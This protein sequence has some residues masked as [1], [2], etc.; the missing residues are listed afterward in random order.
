M[1]LFT[2]IGDIAIQRKEII[3]SPTET[4]I[5]I[6]GYHD[7]RIVYEPVRI[8]LYQPSKKDFL[9]I[10]VKILINKGYKTVN[11]K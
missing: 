1:S 3:Y 7:E 4:Y 11:L 8:L 5:P 9:K 6:R 2:I 10:H